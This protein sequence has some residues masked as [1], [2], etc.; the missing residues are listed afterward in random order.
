MVRLLFSLIDMPILVSLHLGQAEDGVLTLCAV[1]VG[2]LPVM[3]APVDQ[4]KLGR[5]VLLKSGRVDR[6]QL[7]VLATVGHHLVGVGAVVV[8]L[9][10]VKMAARFLGV[11]C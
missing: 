7:L 11:S 2:L 6:V 8:A 10:A 5:S 3:A 1:V 9:E 4:A